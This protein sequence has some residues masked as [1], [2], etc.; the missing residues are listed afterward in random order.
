MTKQQLR[1]YAARALTAGALAGAAAVLPV[2]PA[3]AA[4]GDQPGG[5]PVPEITTTN[6]LDS[7][8]PGWRP[9]AV[10]AGIGG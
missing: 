10:R 9:A 6:A 8:V 2:S 7:L 5:R 1:R 4:A 3:I